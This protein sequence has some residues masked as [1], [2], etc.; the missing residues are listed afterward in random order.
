M[1][2]EF[3]VKQIVMNKDKEAYLKQR[4]VKNYIS[5]EEKVVT[6]E[7]IIEATS[8]TEVDGQRIYK[9]NMPSRAVLFSLTLISKYTDIEIDFNNI[10]KDYNLLDENQYIENLLRIIPGKE[11]STWKTLMSMIEDDIEVNDR[12]VISFLSSK[13][14]AAQILLNSFLEA[15]ENLP[16]TNE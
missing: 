2:V 9:R 10:L 13:S 12:S 6:A 14:E 1:N 16:A 11:M 8:Y 3:F 5:Y 4:L 15:I 7:R